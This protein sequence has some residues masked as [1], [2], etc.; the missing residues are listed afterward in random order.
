MRE[1]SKNIFYLFLNSLSISLIGIIFWSILTRIITTEEYGH[2]SYILSFSIL[3]TNILSFGIFS[4]LWKYSSLNRI[5][6]VFLFLIIFSSSVFL[7]L[8]FIAIF[9][10]KNIY[11]AILAVSLF[12]SQFFESI[13]YGYQRMKE[14]FIS[15]FAS[16][17]LK[18][19]FLFFITYLFGV[20]FLYIV[21]ILILSTIVAIILKLI[22]LK[23]LLLVFFE[24]V[25][26]KINEIKKFFEY[27]LSSFISLIFNSLFS[28]FLVIFGY[29]F[30]FPAI[31][32]IIF[33]SQ[34]ISAVIQFFP[35]IIVS[36]ALPILS[37][38]AIKELKNK[39][40]IS[41]LI[42][43][44][45]N[46]SVVF[47]ISLVFLIS[48]NIN[49]FFD[50]IQ[51]NQEFKNFSF[52]FILTISIASLFLI[53]SN[54]LSSFLFSTNRT[55][56]IYIIETFSI[57]LAILSLFSFIIFSLRDIYSFLFLYLTLSFVR[58]LLYFIAIRNLAALIS[59]IQNLKLMIFIILV[60]LFSINF[61]NRFNDIRLN[62]VV[63]ITYIVFCIFLVKILKIFG[64]DARKFIK[65]LN[66]PKPLRE[67]ILLLI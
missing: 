10:L 19:I 27:S 6:E 12:L 37:K 24:H 66:L 20:N 1:L 51:S 63:I 59:P 42:Q 13:L 61:F 47:V 2:I 4:G 8:F 3:L 54:F 29:I 9:L 58:F 34:Q 52:S 50:L 32:A 67:F 43:Q 62:I 35:S 57:L 15:N 40:K 30:F 48:Y 56:E 11:I 41:F 28:N 36:A 31:S 45:F 46:F 49:L 5:R 64:D 16:S 23:D 38:Y 25:S 14:I 60:F 21:Y 53:L 44:I 33:F 26:F 7:S 39:K 55:K 65:L 22:F 17:F 18:L